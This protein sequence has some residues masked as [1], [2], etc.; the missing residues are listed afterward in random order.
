MKTFSQQRASKLGAKS[1]IIFVIHQFVGTLGI[2]FFA[3]FLGSSIFELPSLFGRTYSMRSLHWILTE[4]PFFPVQI[5]LGLYFGWL[6]GRRYKHRSMLWIWIVPALI[7]SYAVVA[8]PTLTPRPRSVLAQTGTP[9]S[10]YFG[11]GCQPKDRCLDQLL[12]T[13]PFYVA[14]A[15]SIGAWLAFNSEASHP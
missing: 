2:A 1:V 6:L 11:W 13:M 8:V 3:Y 5:A 15:Y 10:H 7:L 14:A 12:I 9:L 4:N